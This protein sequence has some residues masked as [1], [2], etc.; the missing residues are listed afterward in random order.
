[1][2]TYEYECQRCGHRFERFQSMTDEPVKRCP[3]CRG[4]VNRLLSGG[5]GFIFKGS[6]FYITDYRSDQ[7]KKQA[8]QESSSSSESEPKPKKDSK[9]PGKKEPSE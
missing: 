2:P 6:G 7:Y 8:K 3:E 5:A 1:M 4:K 9:P